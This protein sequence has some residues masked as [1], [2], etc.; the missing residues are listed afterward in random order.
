MSSYRQK[1]S[2]ARYDKY[3]VFYR[4]LKFLDQKIIKYKPIINAI[5]LISYFYQKTNLNKV[6]D[7]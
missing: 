1:R 2:K 4:K 6:F 5:S 7:N 3:V